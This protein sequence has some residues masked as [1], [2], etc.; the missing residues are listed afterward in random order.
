MSAADAWP[1]VPEP[2]TV[3]AATI[4]AQRTA[5]REL[6]Y[7]RALADELQKLR[8][9]DRA[10]EIIAA[11]NAPPVVP[12]D[13]GLLGDILA[14]TPEPRDRVSGLIP[15]DG[16]TLVVG[17]RKTSKTTFGLNLADSL[18]TGTPF[19]DRFDVQPITG[20]VCLLNYEVSAA[21]VAHWADDI[22]IDHDRLLLVN[23]RG[24]LNPLT[25]TDR[26]ARL[27]E[28]LRSHDVESLIVDPFGRAYSG[29]SQNDAG[30]VGAWLVTLDAFARTD[31]GA[32]DLILTAHA[33]WNGERTRGSSALE[34]WADSIITLTRDPDDEDDKSRY[35]RATGRIPDVDEDRLKFDPN[36]RRL[37]LTGGGSRKAGR[38]DRAVEAAKV[39]VLAYVAAHPGCSG[40]E[41]ERNIDGNHGVVTMARRA[42][43]AS[44]ALIEGTRAG[45]GGGKAYR[46]PELPP[47]SPE[48]PPGEVT[49]SPTSPLGGEVVRRTFDPEPPPANCP[50]CGDPFEGPGHTPR[51]RPNHTPPQEMTR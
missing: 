40:N 28:L 4:D 49:T 34:D 11:E 50:D 9:R 43:V 8:V 17:Q 38:Q 33:G 13:A 35:M 42:L 14:R 37:S 7:A 29:Q 45:R 31:V 47:T 2:G 44:G 5:D 39:D 12:F 16:S 23:L 26:R 24:G 25:I 21:Q 51:C 30:E 18:I 48:L 1:D 46:I 3:P 27:A 15:A 19:L 22:G 32:R 6:V 36:T 20:R 10:R 41:I